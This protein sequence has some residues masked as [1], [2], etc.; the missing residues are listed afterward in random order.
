M[1]AIVGVS[2][3]RTPFRVCQQFER[4]LPADPSRRQS[5]SGSPATELASRLPHHSRVVID[6]SRDRANADVAIALADVVLV[7]TAPTEAD[8]A[9]T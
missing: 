5:P 4:A 1:A 9:C 6:T 3:A 2:N 8:V 7:P